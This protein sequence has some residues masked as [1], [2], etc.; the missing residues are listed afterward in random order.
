MG[1]FG[2]ERILLNDE[3]FDRKCIVRSEDPFLPQRIL[4]S[5]MQQRF[6]G[7]TLR[8]LELRV[9]AQNVQV[10]MLTIPTNEETF[11]YFIETILAIL[12]KLL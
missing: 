3:E 12:Q 11:D 7:Q 2:K 10:K 9:S 8:S 4:S 6:L 5:D 1:A